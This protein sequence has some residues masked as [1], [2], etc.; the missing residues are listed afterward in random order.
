MTGRVLL[1]ALHV[2][3]HQ[4]VDATGVLVGKVDDAELELDAAG[5]AYLRALLSGPGVLATRLGHAGYG[6]WRE[7]MEH[8]IDGPEGRTARIPIGSVRSIETT[9]VVN[10]LAEQLA[11]YGSERWVADHIIGHIPGRGTA[12]ASDDRPPRSSTVPGLE[13]EAA[14]RLR[15]SSL[16]GRAVNDQEGRRTGIVL[17]IRLVQDGPMGADPS[18]SLRVDGLI[19]G[20]GRFPQRS[21]LLRH[22]VHGPWMLR[23]VAALV[24]PDRRYLR[25][26]DV[27]DPESI[28]SGGPVAA[29]GPTEDLPR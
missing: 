10:L 22:K 21:G 19:V 8:D 1:T 16:L 6:R 17:D 24:G 20:H 12:S 2:L 18:A 3:D 9:V 13:H 5:G 7:R 28:L 29:R 25:W 23:A 11:P 4:L 15:A 26:G 27:D 14:R